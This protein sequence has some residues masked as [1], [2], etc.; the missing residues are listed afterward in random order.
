LVSLAVSYHFFL[1]KE[2]CSGKCSSLV[3]HEK[4][5]KLCANVKVIAQPGNETPGLRV[6]G[7]TVARQDR[8]MGENPAVIYDC[9]SPL[10]SVTLTNLSFRNTH[11]IPF[12]ERNHT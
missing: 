7:Y 10:L 8:K 1:S 12:K 5:R 4:V 2:E 9:C 3:I 6:S 11:F